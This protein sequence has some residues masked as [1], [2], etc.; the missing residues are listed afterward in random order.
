[1]QLGHQETKSI[2]LRDGVGR[3]EFLL[4]LLATT[5]IAGLTP[6]GRAWAQ[7]AGPSSLVFAEIAHVFDEK[8]HVSPGHK[9]QTVVRWGD[10]VEAG[11]PAFDPMKQVP[12]TQAKQF[13]VNND[14]LAFMP[15]PYGSNNS[16]R[17]LLCVNHESAPAEL[18]FPGVTKRNDFAKIGQNEVDI[19]LASIGLSVIEITKTP[20]GW[21]TV[22]GSSY[23][24]RFTL[25][26]TKFRIAG[27]AAGHARMKTSYDADGTTVIGTAY[28]CAGGE[29]PWGTVLSGEEGFHSMFSGDPAKTP[30]A[31]NHRRYGLSNLPHNYARFH[32]RF[33]VEKDP[34]EPNRFGWVVEYDPYTPGSVPV[35]RTSLGRFKHEGATTVLLPDGRVVVYLGDDER[36]ECVYR[37]VSRGRYDPSRREANFNLLDD[38][39]L[40]VARFD[41]DKTVTWLPLVFGQGP[42]TAA[43]GFNSQADVLIDTRRA[44]DLVGATPMD[45]PEDVE[46][47]PATGL[48]Y[49]VLTYNEQR[50]EKGDADAKRRAN[51]ANPWAK[52]LWGHIVEM[53]PPGAPGRN[54][55]HAADKF[56]W[57]F[58]LIAGE[59]GKG[60]EPA[61]YHP[62]T[63]ANGWLSRPDNI[64]FDPRGRMWIG[65]DGMDGYA[66]LADA[67]FATDVSGPGRALTKQFFAAP[68]GAETTGPCFTPDGRTLFVAI[69]HP[70]EEDGSNFD[71]PST[72]WPDHQANLPPRS[73]VVAITREDGGPIGG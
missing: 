41:E 50:R 69:Q 12:A 65:T 30:E 53:T 8:H 34:N 24:R 19:M 20:R 29:T 21:E 72:R 70:A 68:R 23:A 37:F 14:F 18:M 15:L 52:N 3:R 26:E 1:M 11:A 25:G 57:D 33:D 47:N 51:A 7:A 38:G 16:E 59:P 44:A 32:S 10:P 55:D 9:V 36:F 56:G 73:S 60:E 54:A 66:D 5:A 28:N 58:F 17:G 6:T 35:K 48:V 45:R 22:A 39:V 46:A 31:A 63:S 43:N 64:A 2:E 4:G 67:V 71:K 49:V 27:P 13:G 40:S 61:R 42:L 62:A